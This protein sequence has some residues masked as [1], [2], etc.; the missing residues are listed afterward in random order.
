MSTT[1]KPYE[2]FGSRNFNPTG[3][4]SGGD[5]EGDIIW[6]G[7]TSVNSGRLYYLSQDSE[8]EMKWY[9][10]VASSETSSSNLLAVAL[11]TGAASSVGMLIRGM[12]HISNGTDGTFGQPLFLSTTASQVQTTSPSTTGDIV[13]ICGYQVAANKVWFDPDNTYIK[14]S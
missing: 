1:K 9:P 2:K 14:L 6:Y 11:G 7:S 4:A 12:V 10:T 8:G 5:G 3:G 13:R